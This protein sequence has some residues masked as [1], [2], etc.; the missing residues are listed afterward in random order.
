MAVNESFHTNH[1][2]YIADSRPYQALATTSDLNG[3]EIFSHNATPEDVLRLIAANVESRSGLMPAEDML[4]LYK[5]TI[6]SLLG[7]RRNIHAREVFTPRSFHL[8]V[9]AAGAAI[10]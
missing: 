9:A 1:G 10:L 3:R 6:I 5:R 2:Y 8:L 4:D 7:K